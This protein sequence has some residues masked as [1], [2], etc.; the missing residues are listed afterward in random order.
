MADWITTIDAA[1]LSN[2]NTA[3]LRELIRTGKV[4]ARKFGPVWQVDQASL[5]AYIRAAEKS[6]DKRRG[7]KNRS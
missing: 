2:Y 5:L 6:K 7:A 1:K 4:K 3:Y